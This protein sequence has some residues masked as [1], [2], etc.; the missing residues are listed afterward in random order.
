MNCC[1]FFELQ[2]FRGNPADRVRQAQEQQKSVVDDTAGVGGIGSDRQP[3]RSRPEQHT[4]SSARPLPLLSYRLYHLLE[5]KQFLYTLHH[6]G[7]SV[8]QDIQREYV[9]RENSFIFR[10]VYQP[11]K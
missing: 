9:P 2:I 6:N 3:D 7:L 4:R 8:L 10:F 11:Y 5:P 1:L